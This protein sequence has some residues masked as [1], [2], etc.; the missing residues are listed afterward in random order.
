MSLARIDGVAVFKIYRNTALGFV[1]PVFE[2]ITPDGAYGVALR[3]KFNKGQRVALRSREH[4]VTATS[5]HGV[6]AA[7]TL[8]IGSIIEVKDASGYSM[9]NF[10]V[11]N[12]KQAGSRVLGV[13]T[14]TN[15]AMWVEHDWELESV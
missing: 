2:D 8:K 1:R 15:V 14:G 12:V 9:G 3:W 6:T 11:H 13:N 4:L 5:P 10:F 7:W